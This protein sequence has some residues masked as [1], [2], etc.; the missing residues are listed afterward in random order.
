[1]SYTFL[2][3]LSELKQLFSQFS[4]LSDAIVSDSV[5]QYFILHVHRGNSAEHF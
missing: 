5:F 2:K 1:M 3:C 4:S